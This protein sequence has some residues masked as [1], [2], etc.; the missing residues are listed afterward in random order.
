MDDE[1]AHDAL[2]A[3]LQVPLTPFVVESHEVVVLLGIVD[4]GR[5]LLDKVG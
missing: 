3:Q 1:T 2:T 5:Y 4:V